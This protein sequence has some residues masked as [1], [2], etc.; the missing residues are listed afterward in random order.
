MAHV[1]IQYDVMDAFCMDVFQRFGFTK[2]ESRIISDVLLLSDVYGIESHGAQRL[3]RYHKGIASGM[4]KVHAKPEIVFETPVSAVVD[5]HDGMGQLIGHFA[6]DLAIK[7]AKEIGMAIVTVRDSN[8]FGIAGY[9]AKM[10]CDQGARW[11][12]L[13]KLRS[14]RCSDIRQESHAGHKPNC[15]FHAG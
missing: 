9:Y 12:G 2:E 13:Y 10:A 7:K 3:V 8:H 1:K 11:Y 5:G 4:I 6:M 15:Y 14:H